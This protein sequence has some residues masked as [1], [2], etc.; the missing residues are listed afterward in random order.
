MKQKNQIMAKKP[1]CCRICKRKGKR[2]FSFGRKENLDRH[3]RCHTKESLIECGRCPIKFT[4]KSSLKR[5]KLEAHNRRLFVCR[6]CRHL[7]RKN[8]SFTRKESLN[9]HLMCEIREEE[10]QCTRCKIK[11]TTKSS[12]NRHLGKSHDK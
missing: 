1:F 10:V 3:L 11:F 7:G 2:V 8:H 4:T 12:L 5:H 9:R 6:R